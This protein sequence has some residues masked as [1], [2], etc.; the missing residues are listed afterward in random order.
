M[1]AE[2]RGIQRARLEVIEFM[3]DTM[4]L[5]PPDFKALAEISLHSWERLHKGRAFSVD[6]WLLVMIGIFAT[7]DDMR[8][9]LFYAGILGAL[10]A[11]WAAGAQDANDPS[12][13]RA[14]I[15]RSESE[16]AF[17][18][19]QDA[20]DLA[21]N[22]ENAM[23]QEL[24]RDSA[25]ARALDAGTPAIPKITPIPTLDDSDISIEKDIESLESQERALGSIK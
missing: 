8:A 20:D 23:E 9:I 6:A 11:P 22:T 5:L 16:A 3:S 7:G 14:D 19:E 15:T 25:Q 4:R 18:L 1:H 2:I 13:L 21:E 17:S 24:Q 12:K 10:F